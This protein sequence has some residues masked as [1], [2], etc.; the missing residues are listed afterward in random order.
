MKI[1]NGSYKP[2][3]YFP[4]VIFNVGKYSRYLSKETKMY[5]HTKTYIK[6]STSDVLVLF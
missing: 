3:I 1:Q 6:M 5:I 2:N 4:Y